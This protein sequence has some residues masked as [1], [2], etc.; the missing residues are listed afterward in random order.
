MFVT[1]F[2]IF[3]MP[4]ALQLFMMLMAFLLWN[5]RFFLSRLLMFSAWL[6]LIALSMPIVSAQLFT[7]LEAPFLRAPF[8]QI[9]VAEQLPQAVVVLG[10]G[11]IRNTPEYG[12]DQV[13]EGALWRLRYGAVLAKRFD[14]PVIS[15]GGTVY[16]YELTTEAQ[17]AAQVLTQEWGVE[18][19]WQEGNSRDTWRNA[20]ETAALLKRRFPSGEIPAVI[21]VTHAYHMRRSQYAFEQAGLNVIP[22][23]T[24]FKSVAGSGWLN[25]WLPQSIA[26]HQSRTALH[27]YIGLLYYRLRR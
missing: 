21:L 13:S 10:G 22:A 24:G 8:S 14:L 6:S 20:Q 17:M 7:W 9:R 27:E 16:P 26:L 2:K 5:R 19:V 15:S 12:G 18:P 4:P 11:R 25:D 3:L 23:P 1:I